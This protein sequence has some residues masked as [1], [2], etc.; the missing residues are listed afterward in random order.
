MTAALHSWQEGVDEGRP[1]RNY[2]RKGISAMVVC[3]AGYRAG[4]FGPAGCGCLVRFSVVQPDRCQS[5][6]ALTHEVAITRERGQHQGKATDSLAFLPGI[7]SSLPLVFRKG[8]GSC[9]LAMSASREQCNP[10]TISPLH[11]VC[12]FREHGYSPS[13]DSR[14]HYIWICQSKMLLGH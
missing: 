9:F 13:L 6:S 12:S 2:G 3:P 14:N 1:T 8:G 4:P 7:R 10:K 5:A 11:R